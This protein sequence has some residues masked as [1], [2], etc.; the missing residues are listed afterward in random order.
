[1]EAHFAII[2]IL[3][4]YQHAFHSVVPFEPANEKLILLDFTSDNKEITGDILNDTPKFTG[5]INQKLI[6]AKALYG[7]GGYDEHRT[8]YS[9]SKVFDAD[10][11]GEEP[12]RLHLGID[13]W[14]NPHTK[15]IAPL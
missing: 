3:K 14:G 1:M 9:I 8:V 10:K 13:I 12:R 11:P 6:K 15:V 7:I 2:E 5:Y 4:K